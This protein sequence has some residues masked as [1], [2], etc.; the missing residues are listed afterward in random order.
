MSKRKFKSL[1]KTFLGIFALTFLLTIFVPN[2]SGIASEETQKKP[3]YRI[4]YTPPSIEDSGDPERGRPRTA[5]KNPNAL[6]ALI[7]QTGTTP[8]LQK[9]IYGGTTLNSH[10]V[11]LLS[12]TGNLPTDKGITIDL[13]IR[14]LESTG[15]SYYYRKSL[16]VELSS[17]LHTF[18]IKVPQEAAGLEPNTKYKWRFTAHKEGKILGEVAG[19]IERI[20]TSPVLLEQLSSSDLQEQAQIYANNGIW[21][22]LVDAVYQLKSQYPDDEGYQYAWNKLIESYT[23]SDL[24]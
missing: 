5:P 3:F 2:L 17:C 13:E 9:P 21:H 12:Y 7:P 1:K 4:I 20:E 14:D 10:P 23:N 18:S 16:P 19:H 24:D 11:F 8:H 15:N 6:Q 22:E